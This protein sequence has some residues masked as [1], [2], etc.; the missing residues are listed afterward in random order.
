LGEIIGRNKKRG[1]QQ[2]RRASWLAPAVV[3]TVPEAGASEVDPNLKE[4]KVTF[5]ASFQDAKHRP[6][7]PYLLVFKTKAA[8]PEKK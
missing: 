3:K 8:D 1:E 7:V 5:S 6:A 4:I 2:N